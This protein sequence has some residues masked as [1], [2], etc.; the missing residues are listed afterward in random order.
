MDQKTKEGKKGEEGLE[1]MQ[2]KKR[3]IQSRYRG[4]AKE[5]RDVNKSDKKEKMRISRKEKGKERIG[6]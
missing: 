3:V 1:L 6:W 2:I 5:D 4:E